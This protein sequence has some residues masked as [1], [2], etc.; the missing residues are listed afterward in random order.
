MF[1]DDHPPSDN[2][3]GAK[4]LLPGRKGNTQFPP[5]ENSCLGIGRITCLSSNLR[6]RGL[7]AFRNGNGKK[8]KGVQKG[9]KGLLDSKRIE[10]VEHIDANRS[11]QEPLDGNVRGIR[12]NED[13]DS[14]NE[15][16]K[17]AEVEEGKMK[18]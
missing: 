7:N 12:R 2:S 5:F 16:S 9:K 1:L 10:A 3:N 15:P 11:S 4:F 18:W 17:W 8:A 13:M 6:T 14:V